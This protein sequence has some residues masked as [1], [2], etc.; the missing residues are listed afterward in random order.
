MKNVIIAFIVIT[1][2]IVVFVLFNMSNGTIG[3]L[4]DNV[5]T[6]DYCDSWEPNFCSDGDAYHSRTCHDWGCTGG[7]CIVYEYTE[8]ELVDEC[9]FVC[10]SG[11]CEPSRCGN[12][13]CDSTESWYIESSARIYCPEDCGYGNGVKPYAVSSCESLQEIANSPE[14]QYQLTGDI[15]CSD[16]VNWDN[17]QGFEPIGNRDLS[18]DFKGILDGQGFKVTGLFIN[19]PSLDYVGL[20]GSTFNAEIYDIGI[21][22]ADITGNDNVGGLIGYKNNGITRN[23][24]VKGIVSGAE[25]VGGLIG[26][27]FP[28]G[29]LEDS[30]T[31]ADVEGESE[32]GGLV[33]VS[34]TL[35]ITE[36]TYALGE[37]RG[38]S[39]TGGLIGRNMGIIT[40]S[41]AKGNVTLSLTGTR[42]G[43]LVGMNSGT[44]RRS[45]ATG[46]VTVP[47][48][49]S[50][51]GG[52][53]GH[54]S[55][56]I[57]DSY[58][59]GSAWTGSYVGGLVGWNSGTINRTYATGDAKITIESSHFAGGLTAFSNGVIKNS[60]ATGRVSGDNYLGGLVGRL[61]ESGSIINSY[62]FNNM[63]ICCGDGE[64]T[65]ECTKASGYSDFYAS[66]HSVYLSRQWSGTGYP[67]LVGI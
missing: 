6:A 49:G 57:E 39:Y 22:S 50:Q 47:G 28:D 55:G 19:R 61:N 23:T 60:Y 35:C 16:T 29:I 62:W 15:D 11:Q 4:N 2:L 58:S 64:C 17:G 24:Y 1:V 10:D 36:N 44:I 7:E 30:Y 38:G 8:T 67:T 65:S 42:V 54:N 59:T 43:G 31:V 40:S 20:F 48:T 12:G 53:A 56:T 26:K 41:Y 51:A 52:F 34:A 33:G 25:S 32:V 3:C 5:C 27:H 37:V 18:T 13:V 45:Y 21:E 46:Y 66:S 14:S 63:N 9:T